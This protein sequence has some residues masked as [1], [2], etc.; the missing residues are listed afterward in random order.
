MLDFDGL[1]VDFIGLEEQ[2]LLSFLFEYGAPGRSALNYQKMGWSG[3]KAF[4]HFR[5]FVADATG[6]F[7][8]IMHLE[9]STFIFYPKVAF[10]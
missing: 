7:S 2:V 8:P 9:A 6:V 3:Y 1:H 10:C 5:P 4:R